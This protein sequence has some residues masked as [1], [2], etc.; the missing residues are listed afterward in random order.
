[1]AV[2]FSI[3]AEHIVF[4]CTGFESG[5]TGFL[6]LIITSLVWVGRLFY[7]MTLSL[8]GLSPMRNASAKRR[9]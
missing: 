1:M 8:Q 6:G 7:L 5:F 4:W 3:C 2:G 9:E